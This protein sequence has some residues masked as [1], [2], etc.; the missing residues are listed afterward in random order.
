MGVE[1][2]DAWESGSL[3]IDDLH[4]HFAHLRG[5]IDGEGAA[6]LASMLQRE[7]LAQRHFLLDLLLQVPFEESR[8]VLVDFVLD[9]A[10]P[11][12][13]RGRVAEFLLLLDGPRAADALRATVRADAE[14]PYLRRYFAG[15]RES[16]RAEDLALLERLATEAKGYVAQYALQLW[17]R[18]ETD[19][20]ARK[21]IYL[22]A[23]ESSTSYRNTAI[24]ALARQG[25]DAE[26]AAMLL[27]ELNSGT[28]ELR[29]LARRMLPRFDSPEA[30]LEAY[31]ERAGDLSVHLRGRWMIDLAGLPLPEAQRLAMEWLIDGGWDTGVRA[32]QV[33]LLLGRSEEV[34]PLLPV[35]L[36]HGAIPD[37]VLF[38]LALARADASVDARAYLEEKL[39][40][41]GA[42]RQMQIVRAFAGSGTAQ[43]LK[44]LRDIASSAVYATPARAVALEMLVQ[45]EGAKDLVDLWL[46]EPLPDDY[47]RASAWVRS[48]AGS[49]HEPWV[50]AAVGLADAAPGFLDEDERRGLR[51][52][53]W[54]AI[55]RSRMERNGERLQRRLL[56]VM[57]DS[58]GQTPE[59]E[60]W[61]SLYQLGRGFPELGTVAEGLRN[62]APE[63]IGAS[64]E[65][66]EEEEPPHHADVLLIAAANLAYSH[67]AQATAWFRELLTRDL[68]E[69]DRLRVL[70]LMAHRLP[71][72]EARR[73]A[74][75]ALLLRPELF[76]VWRLAMVETFAPQGSSWTLFDERL[77][78][79][80]LLDEVVLGLKEVETLESLLEGYADFG[81]LTNA[82]T[83][84]SDAGQQDLALALAQRRVDHNPLSDQA[85]ARVARLLEAAGHE[86]EAIVHWERVVRLS[87]DRSDLWQAAQEALGEES[88]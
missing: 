6:R 47:E 17:A 70:G 84:A 4:R 22:L 31:K 3:P 26:I 86:Q 75:I 2:L 46:Q 21:R 78:E 27:E 23:R 7:D 77:E 33:V 53:V 68:S 73:E 28:V 34:D 13:E 62:C 36:R 59:G 87:P 5:R 58:E 30:L 8:P 69:V 57:A 14:P 32:E 85:H 49:G 64:R 11:A 44:L 38:P 66:V 48:L 80:L 81:T 67:P 56:A 19:P 37:R 61:V 63:T 60:S 25:P 55:G 42:V 51:L 83:L 82:S 52:E 35:L 71:G 20:E 12:E 29:S 76:D 10:R 45:A 24:D 18:H 41:V 1:I 43:D 65:F 9:E 74:L 50:A 40:D 16:I 72:P 39:P 54:G 88:R 15:W 79:R